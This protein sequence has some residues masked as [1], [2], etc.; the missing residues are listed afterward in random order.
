MKRILITSTEVLMLHFLVPH[1]KN[2]LKNGYEVEVACSEVVGRFEE[3]KDV[4]G[5]FVKIHKVDLKRS[6]TRIQNL[7]GLKELKRIIKEGH[8]DLVWTNE[9]VM[10]VMTRLAAKHLRKKGMHVLY[11]THG[12]HFYKGG[13]WYNWLL[14]YP[15]ERL[16][17]RV[18]DT[19]VTINHEDYALACRRMHATRI[20]YIHGIG[21]DTE[22]FENRKVDVADMRG[23]LGIPE[24]C[25]V[26]L[27][28][29]ELQRRKNH[30][31]I[32]HAMSKT[33]YSKI[34]YIICGEGELHN[35]LLELS[36]KLGIAKH[37]HFLGYRRDISE[38]CKCAD[39]FVHP[40][41]REGLG[42]A[43]LEGMASGLPIVASNINGILD[44]TTDG[45]TG[46]NCPPTDAEAFRE[47]LDKLIKDKKLRDR[48]GKTGN[49]RT[50]DYD[51]GIVK[52]EV[53][54]I[55]E[56]CVGL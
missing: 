13:D 46:Y 47:A 24:D 45:E 34:H 16:F 2:L 42:I 22:Y 51:I 41:R 53:L 8:Y 7:R 12:F 49:Q 32:L 37:V 6:P 27:S 35:Y 52:K 10:G 39:I 9:P 18:T 3:L 26:L 11:M 56:E 17:S 15:I 38:L 1:V 25:M 29:G 54:Q 19:L 50:K 48:M 31:V 28:V 33:D 4:L 21:L 14:F 30:E 5:K 44:Y 23:S 43:A 55:I 40:S 36:E 20:K